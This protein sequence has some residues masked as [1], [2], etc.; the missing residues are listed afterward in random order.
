MEQDGEAKIKMY[1]TEK[2]SHAMNTSQLKYW[3]P[4]CPVTQNKLIHQNADCIRHKTNTRLFFY[5]THLCFI[6]NSIRFYSPDSYSPFLSFVANVLVTSVSK[7][8]ALRQNLYKYIW[9][10]L[11]HIFLKNIYL[12]GC[13][14]VSKGELKYLP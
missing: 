1:M 2:H 8:R 10:T 3:F 5:Y 4:F 12:W 13:Q 6:L 14:F 11:S 9:N 7:I